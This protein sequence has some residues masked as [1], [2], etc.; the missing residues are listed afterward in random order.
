M[1]TDAG[2]SRRII[3][4]CMSE[5]DVVCEVVVRQLY[6]AF[7]SRRLDEAAA[8][9]QQEAVLE[10]IPLGRQQRGPDGYREFAG[11]WLPCLLTTSLRDAPCSIVSA[12]SS[13]R[14]AGS[15]GRI[16]TGR[17]VARLR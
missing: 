12:P 5:E 6:A 2:G 13:M 14:P 16:S 10:H 4:A 1:A 17:S 11:M 8:L 7:N 3:V 9:F 15:S